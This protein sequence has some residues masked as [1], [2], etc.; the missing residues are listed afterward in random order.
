[1]TLPSN[2]IARTA[3][4]L[5][6]G[7]SRH[8][9]SAAVARGELT[10]PRRGWIARPSADPDLLR[11][12]ANGLVIAC[13]TA[14]ERQG[15]WSRSRTA[16]HFAVR[17]A[18]S[19]TRPPGAVLHWGRPIVPRPPG[20]LVEPPENMLDQ[21]ARCVPHEEAVAVWDSALHT[22]LVDLD[23]LRGMHFRG[24]ARALLEAAS[25]F[26]GS[27]L[28]S[29][30][31]LRLGWLRV[32]ITW[33]A[34]LLGH[35]VDFLIGERLVLQIDGGTHVGLQRSADI[36]HDAELRLRGYTVIRVGYVDV[37]ERWPAVQ[38][39]IMQAIGQGLHLRG[40]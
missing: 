1:M 29:Y 37:M 9:I 40:A 3:D 24:R 38:S 31:R 22:G 11:A 26:A 14:A 6:S 12:A 27:G 13:I 10:R 30:V 5:S 15:L 25:P 20:A 19:E 32:S 8:R 7:W 34:W 17:C 16:P 21:V 33:Q 18:G 23:K 2:G 28:E 36:R 35:R 4:L 39:L